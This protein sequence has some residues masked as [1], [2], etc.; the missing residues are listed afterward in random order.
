MLPTSPSSPRSPSV[1]PTAS[2]SPNSLKRKASVQLQGNRVGSPKENFSG[3]QAHAKSPRDTTKAFA[4]KDQ[5]SVSSPPLKEVKTVESCVQKSA[6]PTSL[7]EAI[8][9]FFQDLKPGEAKTQLGRRDTVCTRFVTGHISDV[10]DK[11]TLQ[12]LCSDVMTTFYSSNLI[13]TKDELVKLFSK[14]FS[15]KDICTPKG[16]DLRKIFASLQGVSAQT[17]SQGLG[18]EKSEHIYDAFSSYFSQKYPSNTAVYALRADLKAV[19]G[20]FFKTKEAF[21]GLGL[22]EKAYDDLMGSF[23]ALKDGDVTYKRKKSILSLPKGRKSRQNSHGELPV[24]SPEKKDTPQT[25]PL[26]PRKKE[27]PL[28]HS[29]ASPEKEDIIQTPPLSPRKRNVTLIQRVHSISQKSPFS[30]DERK[31]SP[32]V[33][34][35]KTEPEN[36]QS[37]KRKGT[38]SM[39][40]LGEDEVLSIFYTKILALLQDKV[41]GISLGVKAFYVRQSIGSVFDKGLGDLLTHKELKKAIWQA[42]DSAAEVMDTNPIYAPKEDWLRTLLSSIVGLRLVSMVLTQSDTKLSNPEDPK[43]LKKS[44]DAVN[45]LF[46][47][48]AGF[49]ENLP[50]ME[51]LLQEWEESRGTEHDNT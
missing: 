10:V 19:I 20:Q 37:P 42:L 16:G 4:C 9:G 34:K 5:K 24:F 47:S 31:A 14:L 27:K 46:S 28:E 33:E 18:K 36:V 26:S 15:K 23:A 6:S 50:E 41:S 40:T 43:V 32:H 30:T 17:L 38:L 8:A 13:P 11:N 1:A 12:A 35:G 3:G 7:S 51:K 45:V 39:K 2:P 21:E 44:S 49:P 25:P 29:I 22:S 48:Y